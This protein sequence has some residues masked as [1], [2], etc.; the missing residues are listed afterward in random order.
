MPWGSIIGGAIGLFGQREANSANRAQAKKQMAFQERMSNTA[1]QRRMADL[2]KAGINPI[3]AGKFDATTPAGAMAQIGNEGAAAMEGAAT[4]NQIRLANRL[5]EQQLKNM[6]AEEE[7]TRAQAGKIPAE[8]E[9]LGS[10][11]GLNRAQ[12]HLFAQQIDTLEGQ[13]QQARAAAKK[14]AAEARNINTAADRAKVELALYENLYSG[15]VGAI[16]YAI[17]E[18]AIPI[19]AVGGGAAFFGLKGKQ[20]TGADRAVPD[21]YSKGY[22][23]DNRK[24]QGEWTT[25]PDNQLTLPLR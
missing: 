1:V 3:L 18:L 22:K 11:V 23:G 14:M 10:Q 7:L 24:L 13:E 20:K 12:L 5:Q 15:R 21:K 8:I 6:K 19:A 9:L 17:K 2:R 16:L 25:I 4:G